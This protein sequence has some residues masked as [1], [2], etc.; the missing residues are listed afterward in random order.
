MCPLPGILKTL[1]ALLFSWF[2]FILLPF[3][4]VEV[5]VLFLPMPHAATVRLWL[6]ICDPLV[7]LKST[8]EG[9]GTRAMPGLQCWGAELA[10]H[11]GKHQ[12]CV[13]H[14]Q[15]QS[16]KNYMW[17]WLIIWHSLSSLFNNKA[18]CHAQSLA[19]IF[20]LSLLLCSDGNLIWHPITGFLLP[21]KQALDQ[22]QLLNYVSKALKSHLWWSGKVYYV[23][24]WFYLLKGGRSEQSGLITRLRTEASVAP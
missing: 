16:G 22:V 23:W 9:V 24:P 8:W 11:S 13:A 12:L 5:T 4:L 1:S 20:V 14:W 19:L 15:E 3:V 18:P 10:P 21:V 2:L 7:S 6:C 17:I